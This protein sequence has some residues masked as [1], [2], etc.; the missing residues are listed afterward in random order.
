MAARSQSWKALGRQVRHLSHE[1]MPG[2]G[3]IEPHQ[4]QFHQKK[5]NKVSIFQETGPSECKNYSCFNNSFQDHHFIWDWKCR[6]SDDGWFI[7]S[8]LSGR[9]RLS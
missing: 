1:G 4:L 5:S 2:M 9:R 8:F 3:G 7:H 6:T